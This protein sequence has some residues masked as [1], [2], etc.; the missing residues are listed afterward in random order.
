MM[1]RRRVIGGPD[2][3]SRGSAAAYPRAR[4]ALGFAGPRALGADHLAR[5]RRSNMAQRST[6]IAW[7]NNAYGMEQNLIQVLEAQVRQAQDR[8]D[9]RKRLQDH[10]DETRR[11]AD[12][13][14]RCLGTLG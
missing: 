1:P 7:L 9:I 3:G 4:A 6:M 8:P 12:T 13:V 14:Q 2:E 5:P 10:L 11:H